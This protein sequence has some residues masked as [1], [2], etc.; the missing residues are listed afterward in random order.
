MLRTDV[1]V[2]P[3]SRQ[4]RV[5]AG[6][7]HE[8][9]ITAAMLNDHCERAYGQPFYM[10]SWREVGDLIRAIRAGELPGGTDHA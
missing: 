9:G 10:L 7:M 1:T 6:L 4:I 2:K 8:R 5:V 3:T